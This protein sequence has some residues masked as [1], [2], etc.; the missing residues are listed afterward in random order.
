MS[1]FC[2]LEERY[3]VAFGIVEDSPC[4]FGLNQAVLPDGRDR[5]A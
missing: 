2:F 5:G 1:L 3:V 4:R